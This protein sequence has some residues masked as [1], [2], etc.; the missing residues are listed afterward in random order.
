LRYNVKKLSITAN[1]SLRLFRQFRMRLA[2][3]RDF[4]RR[5]TC[6][7]TKSWA[8]YDRSNYCGSRILRVFKDNYEFLCV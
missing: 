2:S 5:E 4:W 7:S 8:H 3:A 1:F 6:G